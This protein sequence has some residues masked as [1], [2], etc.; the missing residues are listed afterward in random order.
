MMIKARIA[1]S[2]RPGVGKTTLIERVLEWL[3]ISAGGMVTKQITKCGR[4]VGFAVIDI[5]SN[6]EGV[7]AH[8]HRKTGPRIGRYRVN[9]KDLEQIGIAAIER[10]IDKERLIV[11]DEIAPMELCSPRF[12]PIVERAL[13]SSKPLMVSIHA[14]ADH[15]L[16]HRI[17]QELEYFRVKLNNRD[18]LVEKIARSLQAGIDAQG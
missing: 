13:A 10:A 8:M 4:R 16:A 2:G 12:V 9:L 1:I 7:L 15:P 3:P 11:I 18:S 6:R 17:R 5:A 14:H